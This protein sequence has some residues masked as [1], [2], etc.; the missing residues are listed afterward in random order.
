M[1]TLNLT[2]YIF[3][4]SNINAQITKDSLLTKM[5][6]EA[7]IEIKKK[8]LTKIDKSKFETEVGMLLMPTFTKNMKEIQ[9][10]YGN[11]VMTAEGMQNVG[12]ELGIKLVTNCPEFMKLSLDL[13]SDPDASKKILDKKD[14]FS[15]KDAAV[16]GTTTNYTPPTISKEDTEPSK[17]TMLSLTPGT[18]STINIKNKQGKVE[19]LYWFEYFENADYFKNNIS[20]FT[21][22]KINYTYEE[23]DIYDAAKKNYKTIKVITSIA[24]Q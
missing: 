17:G 6:N 23:K 12:E 2:I 8:D 24:L 15:K 21:N 10:V 18:F 13:M 14:L 22:K 1:K 4:I 11:S 20:K 9:E 5:A 3:L 7:C 19:N 16:S